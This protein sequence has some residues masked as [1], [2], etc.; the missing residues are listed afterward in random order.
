MGGEF[1]RKNFRKWWLL[2]EFIKTCTEKMARYLS[3]QSVL[4]SHAVFVENKNKKCLSTNPNPL[5]WRQSTGIISHQNATPHLLLCPLTCSIIT[6]SGWKELMRHFHQYMGKEHMLYKVGDH[7]WVKK[8]VHLMYL[9]ILG[10]DH[11][12]Y[13]QFTHNFARWKDFCPI[14]GYIRS[15]SDIERIV[16]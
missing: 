11:H 1:Y 4:M 6:K 16:W 3:G 2:D 12:W 9:E 15:E 10:R 8:P 13:Q 5:S 14:M 7:M